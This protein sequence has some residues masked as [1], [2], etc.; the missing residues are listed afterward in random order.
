VECACYVVRTAPALV[1]CRVRAHHVVIGKK[2]TVPQLLH[3]LPVG[4][5]GRAVGTDLGLREDHTD[6][7]PA[8]LTESPSR[9]HPGVKNTVARLMR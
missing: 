1:H 9:G 2:V 8:S 4:A 5:H 7:H 3:S 6:L